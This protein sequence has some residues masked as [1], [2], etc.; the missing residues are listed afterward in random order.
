MPA[1]GKV[2]NTGLRGLPTVVR[3][4]FPSIALLIPFTAKEA[5]ASRNDRRVMQG[6]INTRHGTAVAK[7][8]NSIVEGAHK[9]SIH[10]R[11]QK[12]VPRVDLFDKTVRPATVE[13]A[14]KEAVDAKNEAVRNA[15]R[16]KKEAAAAI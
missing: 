5:G 11:Y 1:G 3:L 13:E 15:R 10:T 8:V 14:V 16:M 2:L 4:P 9:A 12:A 6:K 7:M